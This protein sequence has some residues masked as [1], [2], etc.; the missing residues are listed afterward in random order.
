MTDS[1][2]CAGRPTYTGMYQNAV[3]ALC[4][5][6]ARFMSLF[7]TARVQGV[8]LSCGDAGLPRINASVISARTSNLMPSQRSMVKKVQNRP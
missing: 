7:K 2:R 8:I 4:D 1:E 6:I 5:S 3:L